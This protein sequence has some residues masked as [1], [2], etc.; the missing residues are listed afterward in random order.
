MRKLFENIRKYPKSYIVAFLIALVVGFGIFCIFFFWLG[1]QSLVGAINGTGVAGAGLIF[2]FGL[3]WLSRQGAF[4][5][6][7][8]GFSQMF[9][10]MFNKQANKY[11]DMVEYKNEKN[12][13]RAQGSLYYVTFLLAG[14]LYFIAFS[15]LEILLHT[16]Y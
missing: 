6:M 15:I 8:Y 7:S 3:G 12:A 11:N 10:S 14:L 2:I 9:A 1:Q 16:L 13:R 5:T 4:D